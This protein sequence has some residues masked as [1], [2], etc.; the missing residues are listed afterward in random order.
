MAAGG[1]TLSSIVSIHIVS[2]VQ[3]VSI[4][5]V[6]IVS[7]HTVPIVAMQCPYTHSVNSVNAVSIHIVS[8]QE[9]MAAGGRYSELVSLQLIQL[10]DD[11]DH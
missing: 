2:I 6:P 7:I 3:I 8:M 10:H 1:R 5:T 11:S 4:Y 9:L